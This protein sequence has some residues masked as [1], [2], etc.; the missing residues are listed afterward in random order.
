MN[1]IYLLPSLLT[2][3]NLFCGVYAIVLALSGRILTGAW[4]ILVAM[5]FDFMDGQVAR[6]KKATSRFGMEYDSLA[7]LVSFGLAPIIIVYL[8][9]LKDMGRLGLGLVFIYVVCAALRLARFNTQK[10]T[11]VKLNFSGLPT[12]ASG[13]FI[14]SSVIFITNNSYSTWVY[15][16][17]VVVLI[18]SFLMVSTFKYP[19]LKALNL[20]KKKPF[21]NL[22]AIILCGSMVFL[23]SEL[24]L[25]L[26]FLGYILIGIL[27]PKHLQETILNSSFEEQ[28]APADLPFGHKG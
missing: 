26:C 15:L 13:G 9:F 25:F 19:S 8:M 28:T 11:L 24:F 4:I 16:A 17:P 3:G 5:F 21:L 10:A 20:W 18:L 12:P 6:L 7:D 1:K 22:V 23:H 27:K 2:T 14:A